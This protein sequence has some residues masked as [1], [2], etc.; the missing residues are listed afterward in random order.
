MNFPWGHQRR[1]NAYSEY[2]KKKFGQRIQKVSVDAGFTCPNRDGTKGY[3]GCIYCNND[4]F[5]PSY[6]S[7]S[8]SIR[9]QIEEGIEFHRIRYRRARKY[10]VYFQTYS[11]TYAPL[12]QLREV[13]HEA[14]SV[15]NVAGLIIGTR[16]DCVNEQI[17]DYLSS[18]SEQ[19][20]ILIEYGVESC[21]DKTLEL[22]N[23]RHTF[24]DSIHALEMT[25]RYGVRSGIHLIFGLP[26][27]TREE[28]IAQASIL[29]SL[30]FTTLKI[31]Q[32]QIVRDTPLARD[33]LQDPGKYHFYSLQEYIDL[34]IDFLERLNPRIVIERFAAEVPPRYLIGP[35][36]G[37][38]RYDVILHH[39]EKRLQERNTWQGK[40]F[41]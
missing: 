29:S 31:H 7:P 15:E 18:L 27:E 4:A 9:R 10:L 6:C 12:D 33:Y 41:S 2:F 30:P 36:W 19:Y 14:L 1:F 5:N 23:R 35:N 37:P 28:I 39:F 17:L 32:L 40:F 11:N 3:G 22:I 20:Y 24:Q 8:K 16:P 13:Y 38:M 26:G 34:V 21:Y 25:Y